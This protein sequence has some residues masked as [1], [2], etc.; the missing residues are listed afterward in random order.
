MPDQV[1]DVMILR[2]CAWMSRKR[3]FSSSRVSARW[4]WSRPVIFAER[5]PGL[6]GDLAVGFRREI[7]DD[8]RGVDVGLD[9]RPTLGRPAVV[10]RDS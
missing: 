5:L 9:T 10:H 4:V 8:F 2:G 6:D 1:G 3:I 7:E